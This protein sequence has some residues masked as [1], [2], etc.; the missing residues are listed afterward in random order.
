MDIDRILIPPNREAHIEQA[1]Q[2]NRDEVYDAFE[3]DD[4]QIGH[5][6]ESGPIVRGVCMSRSG[7]RRT[8]GSSP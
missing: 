7:A 3:D 1:H 4:L 8:D 5:T 2:V 6:R